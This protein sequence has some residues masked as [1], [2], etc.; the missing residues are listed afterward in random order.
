MTGIEHCTNLTNL[1]LAINNISN[2]SALTG[3]TDLHFLLLENNQISDIQ[4]IVNNSGIATSDYVSLQCNPLSTTSI[5]TCIPALQARGATVTYIGPN[6]TLNLSPTN[7]GNVTAPNEGLH[8]YNCSQ[9]VPIVATADTYY[10]FINWSG[11]TSTIANTS[12][13]NTTITMNGNYSIQANFGLAPTGFYGDANRDGLLS[14]LDYSS[15]QLM[16][17]GQYPKVSKYEMQ[18]DFTSGNGSNKWAKNSSISAPPPAL[19]KT[20]ET[21]TGWANASATQYNNI[22]F[23]NDS[24][25]WNIS[26]ANG[27]YAAM[28]CKFTIGSI[29][30]AAANIT[31]IGVTLN[32]S[33]KTNGDILQLWAWN[34]SAGSWK[35]LGIYG[36]GSTATNFSMTT[37]IATYSAWT[38]WG[39]VYT[40]Y[41][42]SNGYM[43]ILA[44]LN[45]ASESLYVDYIKL[46]VAHP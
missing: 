26:G 23:A 35:Q 37:N 32:G 34:F 2:I 17:F 16:R 11:N 45:N 29:V 12:A 42:D 30:G 22:S 14:I 13:A 1:N 41:I 8:T 44:N 20:F 43:Y 19:N 21:D 25:V 6:Y 9:V 4:P 39:K 3:L 28:Q 27:K 31:S 33:A 36:S 18:Y 5:N 46:T 10:R 38:A 7:G 40:N 24:N 15:V